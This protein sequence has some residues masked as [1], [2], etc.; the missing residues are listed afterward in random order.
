MDDPELYD[1]ETVIFRTSDVFIKSVPFEAVLTDIRI[2]FT[3][4]KKNLIPTKEIPLAAVRGAETGENA[5]RDPT[6]TLTVVTDSGEHRQ[7]VLT[8][9]RYGGGGRTRDRDEWAREIRKMTGSAVKNVFSSFGKDRKKVISEP[10][11]EPAP[12]APGRKG[13]GK[14]GRA[15]VPIERMSEEQ[16]RAEEPVAESLPPY[17]SFCTKCGNRLMEGSVFC[18]RCGARVLFT[19]EGPAARQSPEEEPDRAPQV[20]VEVRETPGVR[21]GQQKK[22][23]KPA[24]ARKTRAEGGFFSRIFLKKAP[25]KE[26]GSPPAD[27][28]PRKARGGMLPPGSG[29]KILFGAGVVVVVILVIAAAWLILP[30]LLKNGVLTP[31]ATDE[32]NVTPSATGTAKPS[33]TST[34][35]LIRTEAT[36]M[37]IPTDGVYVRV[38]YLGAWQ[39]TYGVAGELMTAKRSGDAFLVVENA[40]GTIQATFIKNDASTRPHELFVEIY[41]K[42]VLVKRGTTT[43]PKGKVEI[44]VNIDT[45][46]A[47]TVATTAQVNTTVT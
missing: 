6:L 28:Q 29:K 22:V 32:G 45:A 23:P 16:G 41:K 46:T 34:I 1:N 40:T 44:S 37:V 43:E 8:F 39:G 35:T 2:I 9:S 11:A 13:V 4:R 42:G 30:N 3:D 26:R 7:M 20:P 33:A 10:Q 15:V 38:S 18:N 21:E 47:V 36:P 24:P 12:A 31:G 14:E 19:P 27:P 5:I 17:G 25:R